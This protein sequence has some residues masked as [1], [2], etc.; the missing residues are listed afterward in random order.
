MCLGKKYTW[1]HRA[2]TIICK[3]CIISST[4]QKVN[5][6]SERLKSLPRSHRWKIAVK[7]QSLI[8]KSLCF[9]RHH[10]RTLNGGY[11]FQGHRLLLELRNAMDFC[12][13]AIWGFHGPP[14]S[15]DNSQLLHKS[16]VKN[17]SCEV[18]L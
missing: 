12:S 3:F 17:S 6:V 15:E 14:P 9:P 8:I 18:G 11:Y 1:P 4:Y 10:W 13:L 7:I 5:N 16:P 2:L